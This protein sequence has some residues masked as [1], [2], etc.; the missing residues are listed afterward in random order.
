MTQG[1]SF[2]L[3]D[4]NTMDQSQFVSVFG[5]VFEETPWAA[6][7]AFRAI[8]FSSAEALKDCMCEAIEDAGEEAQL[9][10]LRAHPELGSK[11]KMAD[12]SVKEQQA[13][14]ITDSEEAVRNEMLAL[15]LEYREKFDFPFIIAVKGLSPEDILQN[16]QRRL[17]NSRDDE[18]RECLGQVMRIARFRLDDLIEEQG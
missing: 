9:A 13:A 12:A 3:E 17:N 14:G 6:E 15:N 18:F 16:M 10:L 2:A 4:I 1:G 5:G 7:S 11:A 8:P